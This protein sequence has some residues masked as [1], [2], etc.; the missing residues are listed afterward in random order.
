MT[1]LTQYLLSNTD[2]TADF[3]PNSRYAGAPLKVMMDSNG[4]ERVFVSRRFVPEPAAEGNAP[5][6]LV[7]EG[8]RLDLLGAAYYA[9]PSRWWHIAD[10]NL[11]AH[12][13][14]LLATPGRKIALSSGDG[15]G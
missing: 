15:E 2:E 7:R 12:P 6:L 8:D 3:A 9:E 1:D 10:A 14:D 4:I 5:M 13:G 11:E